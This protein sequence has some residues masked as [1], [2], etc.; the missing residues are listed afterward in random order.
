MVVVLSSG[1]RL[2]GLEGYYVVRGGQIVLRAKQCQQV[3]MPETPDKVLISCG[4]VVLHCIPR[5]NE[6]ETRYVT[7]RGIAKGAVALPPPNRSR[8]YFS[9]TL[10]SG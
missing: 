4:V 1:H 3:V 6:T 7:V 9:K 8:N 10:K 2:I 5:R